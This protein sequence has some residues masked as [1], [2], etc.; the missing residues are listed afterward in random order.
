MRFHLIQD[1]NL[2]HSSDTREVIHRHYLLLGWRVF[3]LEEC[4]EFGLDSEDIF[5]YAPW[6]PETHHHYFRKEVFP[7]VV[8]KIEGP[9]K[10]ISP[11]TVTHADLLNYGCRHFFD[12][13]MPQCT[14]WVHK[15]GFSTHG[16][17]VKFFN[18]SSILKYDTDVNC[19]NSLVKARELLQCYID[20]PMLWN[21]RKVDMRMHAAVASFDPFIVITYDGR[22]IYA[23]QNYTEGDFSRPEALITNYAKQ[24]K[25]RVKA[26]PGGR[27]RKLF[28]D[29]ME[30]YMVSI[31]RVK[32]GWAERDLVPK[33]NRYIKDYLLAVEPLLGGGD[34]HHDFI[35]M[36]FDF[37]FEDLQWGLEDLEE[38]EREAELKKRRESSYPELILEGDYRVWLGEV[39]S[40]PGMVTP[41]E[42]YDVL[43]PEFY[44]IVDEIHDL[45]EQQ[46]PTD[47]I[48]SKLTSVKKWRW[49]VGGPNEA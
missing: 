11:P 4:V 34:G 6:K 32:E 12:N 5:E 24:T 35:I 39:Q 14:T 36:G 43:I 33:L 37:L 21:G 7:T 10:F 42:M 8:A 46:V 27:F 41:K 15:R 49:V 3:S 20:K 18:Q 22:F 23:D 16:K 25:S 38:A 44:G 1:W 9:T 28:F 19:A 47:Q 17:S 26:P 30:E 31:G 13:V 2:H 45:R 29:Q 48:A 40:P